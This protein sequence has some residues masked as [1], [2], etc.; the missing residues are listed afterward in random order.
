[1]IVA[2]DCNVAAA[3][4]VHFNQPGESATATLAIARELNW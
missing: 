1:M 3:S 4:L 2:T